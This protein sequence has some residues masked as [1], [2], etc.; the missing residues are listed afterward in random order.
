VIVLVAGAHGGSAAVSWA[1]CFAACSTPYSGVSFHSGNAA[2]L[3]RNR[4][5]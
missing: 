5:R 3:L 2:T 1:C 4:F